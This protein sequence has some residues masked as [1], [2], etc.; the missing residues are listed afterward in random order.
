MRKLKGRKA[1]MEMSVGTIVTI[2]LLV[3]VLILGIFLISRIRETSVD[4]IS[5]TDDAITDE[6]N[7]LFAE[8]KKVMIYPAK[9][10]IPMKQE[11]TSAV[12][13]GIRNLAQGTLSTEKFSYQTSVVSPGDCRETEEQLMSWIVQGET[14]DEIGIASGDL[15]IRKIRFRVPLGASLCLP[16]YRVDVYVG[17]TPYGSEIF[18]VEVQSK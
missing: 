13:I 8:D 10:I 1:A 3:S 5:M 2:V 18:D 9:G 7:K 6:L 12:G 14:E 4:V 15:I 11:E 17:D 16:R